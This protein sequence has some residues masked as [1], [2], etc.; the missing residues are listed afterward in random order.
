MTS[1]GGLAGLHEL[2]ARAHAAGPETRIQLRDPIA[3]YGRSA[4]E[5]VEPWIADSVPGAFAVRVLERT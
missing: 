1:Y 2:L 4:I 3:A 5:A